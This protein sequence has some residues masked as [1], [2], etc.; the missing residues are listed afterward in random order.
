MLQCSVHVVEICEKRQCD[1][2][3][4]ARVVFLKCIQLD[5]SQ[6]GLALLLNLQVEI[7]VAMTARSAAED[8]TEQKEETDLV[9]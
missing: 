5:I 1:R 6:I 8:G 7:D 4:N 3:H 2:P 9:L